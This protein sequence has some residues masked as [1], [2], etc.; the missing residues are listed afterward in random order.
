MASLLMINWF[1]EV[2]SVS[3]ML[4]TGLLVLVLPILFFAALPAILSAMT[5]NDRT[6]PRRVF[7]KAFVI[8]AVI[9]LSGYLLLGGVTLLGR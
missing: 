9:M 8:Q 5:E 3:Q 2:R 4:T 1:L 7:I 6:A